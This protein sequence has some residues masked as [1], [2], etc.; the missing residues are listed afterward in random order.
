[1]LMSEMKLKWGAVEG[2][3]FASWSTSSFLRMPE[4]PGTHMTLISQL[5]K[6]KRYCR[7]LRMQRIRGGVLRL[8]EGGV[9]SRNP[10]KQN[11]LFSLPSVMST[12]NT[13]TPY[14]YDI[15]D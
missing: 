6:C 11:F 12:F 5:W 10:D 2:A 13:R 14:V 7:I 9:T 1:M 8:Y 4:W 15:N 3:D